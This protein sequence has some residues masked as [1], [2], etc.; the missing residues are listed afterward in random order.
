MPV[1]FTCFLSELFCFVLMGTRDKIKS[2][3]L[4]IGHEFSFGGE[5]LWSMK[6]KIVGAKD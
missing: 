2:C 3:P 6:P 1:K 4:Y 5:F